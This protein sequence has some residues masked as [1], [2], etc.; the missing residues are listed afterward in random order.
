MSIKRTPMLTALMV[1]AIGLGIGVSMTVLTVNYLMAKDPIPSKSSQLYN[2]QLFS[3]GKG[4]ENTSSSDNFPMQLTYQ[5]VMNLYD[6]EIPLRKTRSLQTGVTVIPES[7]ELTPF[8]ES[9]RAIDSEFFAMFNVPFIYGGTW[10]KEVDRKARN[11]TVIGRELNDRL[12][13]GENSVGRQIN[14][15]LI[16][17]TIV[18]VIGE[19]NPAP[20]YYDLV[21]GRFD[22]SEDIF[23]P[24]SLVPVRELPALAN[25]RSWRAEVI[26]TYQ[27]RL[28]SEIFWNQFWVELSNDEQFLQF[29][30]WLDGYVKQQQTLNRFENKKAGASLKNVSQWMQYNEVVSNDSS[31]LVGLSFMF[32]AVCMINTIGL[33]LAKFLRRAPEVG[34]RRALGAS[35]NAIFSQHLVDVGLIGTAGGVVGLLLGQLGLQGVKLLYSDYSQLVHMDITLI[36]MA[37]F[38]SL[39]SSILA[40]LYPA[41]LICK[42]NPSLYLK[43]Q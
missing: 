8:L 33:L 10:D 20:R 2:V 5:D 25:S 26:E 37:I 31:I 11:V 14:F 7:R 30:N 3:F 24:F 39:S 23:I 13:K 36:V 28:R 1:L 42:T 32:L 40:G 9:T 4:V 27:D 15:D 21:N 16:S 38:I 43:T 17:Y 41:W 29:N 22:D 12:F 19:W 34:V 6:S 18:G 35:R